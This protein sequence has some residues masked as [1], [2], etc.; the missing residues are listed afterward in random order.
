MLRRLSVLLALGTTLGFGQIAIPDTPAGRTLRAW[1]EAFNSGNQAQLEAYIHTL[2][3]KQ[4]VEGMTAFRNQTG[5]FELLSIESS[6]P[7]L[8]KFRVKE[9]ASSTVGLGS[10]QVKNAQT[11]TVEHFDLHA[12]PAGAAVEDI[13]LDAAERQRVIDEI[14]KD[15]NE[16]Y[17]Y[18]EAAKKMADEL[19]AHESRGDFN[20][21]T[22]GN[23][24]RGC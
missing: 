15:L 21:I 23:E 8:I 20:A 12:I 9:K 11:A 13:K 6:E 14:A 7:L 10:L 2:D 16:F 18:P 19:R 17:V 24:L 1:L 3:P 22:D 4:S 5:G